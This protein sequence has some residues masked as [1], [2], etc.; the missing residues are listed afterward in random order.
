MGEEARKSSSSSW[1]RIARAVSPRSNILRANVWLSLSVDDESPFFV[2]AHLQE[3]LGPVL[4]QW[5]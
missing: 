2:S 1:R 3:Q 5:K 4:V